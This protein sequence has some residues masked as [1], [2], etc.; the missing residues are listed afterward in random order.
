M[1]EFIKAEPMEEN[2]PIREEQDIVNDLNMKVKEEFPLGDS[3]YIKEEPLEAQLDE[4]DEVVYCP[5]KV[6]LIVENY[7]ASFPRI[8]LIC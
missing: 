4:I 2:L 6:C 7:V 1:D 3:I 5:I 8:S